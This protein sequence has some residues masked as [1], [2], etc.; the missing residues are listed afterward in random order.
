MK[1]HFGDCV[2]DGE[3]HLVARGGEVVHLP[4]K[5]FAL[6]ALLIDAAPNALSRE[7]IYAAL[8]G[9]TFVE[10]GSLHALVSE[11]RIAIGD[12]GREIIRTIHRFGYAFAAPL[13]RELPALRSA[14]VVG[15][16]SWPLHGGE[17]VVGRDPAADVVIDAA[18]VSRRHA[19]IRVEAAQARVADLES[20]NGTFLGGAPVGEG[21]VLSDGDEIV[22]GTVAARWE[23]VR[24]DAS[25]ETA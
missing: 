5:A 2:F 9:D 1:S 16:R 23:V 6:L 25:T 3:R 22:F 14:L 7:A 4:P 15:G 13:R 18:S 10:E 12:E 24:D 20:K 11:L 21:A 19:V 17:N 8:W